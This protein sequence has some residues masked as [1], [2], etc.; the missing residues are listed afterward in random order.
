MHHTVS[1]EELEIH[2]KD[3]RKPEPG[4]S[5][6]ETPADDT[7]LI[8]EKLGL[9]AGTFGT[10]FLTVRG[11]LKACPNCGRKTSFLDILNDG[12]ANHGKDFIKGVVRGERG[13]VYNSD[14]PR[15]HK[16]FGCQQA[17]PVVVPGY[18]CN[19]YCCG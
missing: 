17:S 12:I 4:K 10:S 13:C 6:I 3:I 9:P 2:L 7:K 18:G 1:K 8:E 19:G 11:D 16:C 5:V 15:P 14:P